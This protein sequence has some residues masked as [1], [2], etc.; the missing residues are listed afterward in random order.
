MEPK[1][2]QDLI[3]TIMLNLSLKDIQSLILTDKL[4]ASVDTNTF[5]KQKFQKDFTDVKNISHDWKKRIL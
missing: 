2:N 5:W 1:L 4:A 3:S